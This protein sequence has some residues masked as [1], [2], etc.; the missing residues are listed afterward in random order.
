[1][2]P[3]LP[4]I[5]KLP[6]LEGHEC[7]LCQVQ[8]VTGHCDKASHKKY[9]SFVMWDYRQEWCRPYYKGSTGDEEGGAYPRCYACKTGSDT[10][11]APQ[12]TYE[13]M[14]SAGHLAKLKTLDSCGPADWPLKGELLEYLD[15]R[16]V[17]TLPTSGTSTD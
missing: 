7:L 1:M 15:D 6:W 17:T 10:S 16:A 9:V 14:I 13:H 3:D 12:A 2:L 5:P 4:R 11:I 8:N